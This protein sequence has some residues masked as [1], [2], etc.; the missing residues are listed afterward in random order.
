MYNKPCFLFWMQG[1]FAAL[2]PE[3]R[4]E[5]SFMK[6]L[7][8]GAPCS[9]VNLGAGKSIWLPPEGH[10]WPSCR[11]I[12][13]STTGTALEEIQGE[14]W[15]IHWINR[16]SLCADHCERCR[17]LKIC[18]YT[19]GVTSLPNLNYARSKWL[20]HRDGIV[21][22]P[23]TLCCFF[24]NIPEHALHIISAFAISPEAWISFIKMN[25]M[26]SW[27]QLVSVETKCFCF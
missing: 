16:Y 18:S 23:I 1:K 4:G 25:C 13:D 2:L 21:L 22:A 15:F 5:M 12:S 3:H 11:Y 20:H 17:L 26:F 19:S 8:Q 10:V 14:H 9:L 7:S 24:L 6:S 27:W